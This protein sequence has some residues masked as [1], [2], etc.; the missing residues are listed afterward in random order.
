MKGHIHGMIYMGNMIARLLRRKLHTWYN[1]CRKGEMLRLGTTTL[2]V[3][4]DKPYVTYCI[5]HINLLNS[6]NRIKL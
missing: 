6:K 5:E 2:G 3:R 1:V 4:K